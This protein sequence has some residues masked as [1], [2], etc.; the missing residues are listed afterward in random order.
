MFIGPP[1]DHIIETEIKGDISLFDAERDEVVVLN[2]TASDIWR[3][4]DGE[5]TLDQIVE[6]LARAYE[7][8]PEDIR[9]DVVATID[10]LTA[11]G[12]LPTT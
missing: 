1:R 8:E 10:E 7:R 11:A 6:L 9:T 12:F 3:L 4:C 5:Q 2:G